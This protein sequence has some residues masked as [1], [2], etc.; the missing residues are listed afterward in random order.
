M[1]PEHRIIPKDALA[2][3]RPSH[4]ARHTRPRSLH[5]PAVLGTLLFL[6]LFA[7]FALL[8]LASRLAP[9]KLTAHAPSASQ[10]VST[11][12]NI[13]AGTPFVCDV[14]IPQGTNLMS[15]P[16]LPIE[17]NIANFLTHFGSEGANIGAL[18]KYTPSSDGQWEAYNGSLPNWTV[19][20][21]GR[22]GDQDGI[23]LVMDSGD[24][25]VMDGYLASNSSITLRT[26]WN[27]VGWPTNRTRDLVDAV[28]S[29]N[30]SYTYLKTLEGTEEAGGYLL[31]W[32]PPG[33]D[34]LT[35]MSAYHGYWFNMSANDLWV[36][37]K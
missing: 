23:Y 14:S 27:L 24:T 37:P 35:N 3:V 11:R 34:S 12:V 25:F 6:T 29:V 10:N 16:C 8:I 9:D 13:T 7:I 21:L 2:R 15:F 4:Q 17:Y 19:Q 1:K 5:H 18:Y 32:P 31:D 22:F 28:R 30:T 20:T 26:G 36:V 33:A